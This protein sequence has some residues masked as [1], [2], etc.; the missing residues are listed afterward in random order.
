VIGTGDTP[1][2]PYSGGTSKIALGGGGAP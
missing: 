2:T 1:Y